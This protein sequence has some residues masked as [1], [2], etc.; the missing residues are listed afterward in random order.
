MQTSSKKTQGCGVWGLGIIIIISFICYLLLNAKRTFV[1]DGSLIKEKYHTYSYSF[2]NV[3]TD[4]TKTGT[5]I[6]ALKE[7]I[8]E[9]E[10]REFTDESQTIMDAIAHKDVLVKDI[11]IQTLQDDT[12]SQNITYTI[13]VKVNISELAKLTSQ[14]SLITEI[15]KT[16]INSIFSYRD[17]ILKC[18]NDIERC[19]D[20]HIGKIYNAIRIGM[21]EVASNDKSSS[22]QAS[23][24]VD[25][26]LSFNLNDYMKFRSR[27]VGLL[28]KVCVAKVSGRTDDYDKITGYDSHFW[29][30]A[31]R[32]AQAAWPQGTRAI[33][34]IDEKTENNTKSYDYCFY[35][36]PNQI[37]QK[38]NSLT[39]SFSVVIFQFDVKGGQP[40]KKYM[41]ADSR[42]WYK[43]SGNGVYFV[44]FQNYMRADIENYDSKWL[45]QREY[46]KTW[47]FTEDQVQ[48]MKSCTIKVLSG[49]PARYVWFLNNDEEYQMKRLACDGY[50]PA[51][52]A[53]AENW[54]G[55]EEWYH[56]AALHGDR[57]AQRKIGWQNSGLGFEIGWT[58]NGAPVV[59]NVQKGIPVR[60]G[61]VIE[62]IN[63]QMVSERNARVELSKLI[64]AIPS[65]SSV[66][67]KFTNGKT[68]NLKAQK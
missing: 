46:K 29:K 44:C 22:L 30:F 60:K 56:T 20:N 13:K 16:E 35:A 58:N 19:F 67:I 63:G 37:Y 27:M 26:R 57:T 66:E 40:L 52:L 17:L 23:L 50:V 10:G 65:G 54:R 53:L 55:N 48:A 32:D 64:G 36:V 7:A 9:L 6:Q 43:D 18:Q 41:K 2:T 12:E 31:T 47:H 61:M 45:S 25:Y 42:F 21:F 62:S 51:M 15:N 49:R 4:Y 11:D 3:P 33:V 5:V 68:L 34:F 1:T 39:D 14:K 28:E 8:F 59:Y 38:I 24:N